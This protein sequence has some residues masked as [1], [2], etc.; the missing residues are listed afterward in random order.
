M[1]RPIRSRAQLEDFGRERLSPNFFMRDFLY[2]EIAATEGMLNAPDDP[3]LALAS[4]RRLC[5]YL[6]EPLN[7][8]FGRV[9][10]RSAYRSSAVNQRGVDLGNANCASNE[11]N[12][13]AHI[14]D[15]RDSEG[16]MGAT[17][18][19]V[20]PWL[21]DHRARGG[22]WQ[23]LAWWVHDH[24]PYCSLEF[25]SKLTAFNV[26]WREQPERSIYSYIGGGRSCLT[27]PGMDNHLGDHSAHYQGFPQ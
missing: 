3:D 27:R 14:W 17:A 13:A 1:R 12:R 2:S 22:D 25:F 20:L 16:R 5:E 11:S 7:A 21:V 8:R 26:Q 4:G 23:G 15:Q 9:G 24:L 6:L 18:S 19:V 10:I